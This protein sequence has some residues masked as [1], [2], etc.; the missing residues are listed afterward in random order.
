M[1]LFYRNEKT[2]VEVT[3]QFTCFLARCFGG[4]HSKK[5]ESE[6]EKEGKRKEEKS[7]WR[8]SKITWMSTNYGKVEENVVYL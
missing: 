1:N 5:E 3:V 4:G 2:S 7:Y 6:E 8:K